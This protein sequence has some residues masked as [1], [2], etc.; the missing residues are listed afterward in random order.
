M[1]AILLALALVQDP[2]EEI[3]TLLRRLESSTNTPAES[4]EIVVRLGQ[5]VEQVAPAA[6]RNLVGEAFRGERMPAARRLDLAET[7]VGLEDRESWAEEAGRIALD[8]TEAAETRMR[9]ALLLARAGAPRAADVGRT[10]DERL[11]KE[12][13]D[14]AARAL[15]SHLRDGPSLEQQ[16][17]EMDYLFRLEVPAATTALREALADDDV[18]A[19]IRLEIAERLHAAGKLDRPRDARAALERIRAAD[20]AL[21][22]RVRK[23]LGELG[24]IRE[25]PASVVGPEPRAAAAK[26]RARA[27]EDRG[28]PGR[29]NVIVGG[30]TLV[31]LALLLGV[32][33]RS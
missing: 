18:A 14:E 15:G 16:R 21:G 29:V 30:A 24:E 33:R 10:L 27:V 32:R 1:P 4:A 11:F 3:R 28:S 8:A 26:K 5:A 20:P 19:A 17:R 7:L 2:G 22:D 12:G 6:A 9:A 23:L 25:D 13:T 31:L